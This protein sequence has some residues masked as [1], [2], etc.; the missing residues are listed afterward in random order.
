LND[1]AT[2]WSGPISAGSGAT[3]QNGQCT[4][5]AAKSSIDATG[6]NLTINASL[7]FT[8]AF[9]GAKTVFASATTP[10]ASTGFQA[11]GTWTAR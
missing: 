3:L 11:V 4:L 6:V 2:A 9:S 7:T 10:T 1:T 5:N 8:S